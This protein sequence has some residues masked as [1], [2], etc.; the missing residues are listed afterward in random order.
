MRCVRSTRLLLLLSREPRNRRPVDVVALGKLLEHMTFV[1]GGVP[2][3]RK[4]G[5]GRKS[6][7]AKLFPII[8]IA[9]GLSADDA[10]PPDQC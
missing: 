1:R 10:I 6:L 5:R 8:A 3:P 4:P 2:G 9:V 7:A